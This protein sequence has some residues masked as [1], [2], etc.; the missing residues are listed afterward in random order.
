[1]GRG[2]T[3][4][5]FRHAF[6]A[7][8]HWAHCVAA[9]V[10]ALPEAHEAAPVH[11]PLGFVYATAP[12]APD[13]AAILSVL[14]EATGVAQWVGGVGAG[15]CATG[16]EV[17][18][19]PALSVM[20]AD[21]P[22][23]AWRIFG[24][25]MRHGDMIEDSVL[26]WAGPVAPVLGVVHGDAANHAMTFLVSDLADDT[27]GF[28]VGGLTGSGAEI[29]VPSQVAGLPTRGGL[30]G[31]LMSSAV[32][33]AVGVTQGCAPIGPFHTVTDV[34]RAAVTRLDGR[35]P[36]DV[37][38][39]ETGARGREDLRDLAGVVHV[40]VQV[41]G[42]DTGAYAVRSLVA[43]DPGTGWI[44]P[45]TPLVPGDRIRFV[46]R[47]Q[48]AAEE[49]MRSMLARLAGRLGGRRPR[50][51]IYVS[52]RARGPQLFGGRDREIGLI[53]EAMGPFPLTGFF[54]TGE[55]SHNRLC[56]HAGVL[57]L[58]L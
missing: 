46:R 53:R 26:D 21:L 38:C 11:E 41:N 14:R 36:L 44:A 16:R 20:I 55:I 48:A 49:D 19:A 57:T 18:G 7:G 13:L 43:I 22:R 54:G 6:A 5:P 9:C 30:S 35:R 45:A 10:R 25:L 29:P 52:C 39:A 12:L 24:T 32:P 56:S 37:L 47:T 42:S 51:G 1:M 15:I 40:G 50:G 58:F 31:V 34:H 2:D 8:G 28:L 3:L 27:D 4:R 23:D 17:H 33:V